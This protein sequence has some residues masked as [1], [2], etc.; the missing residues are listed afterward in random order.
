MPKMRQQ[1]LESTPPLQ[2]LPQPEDSPNTGGYSM[3]ATGQ[4]VILPEGFHTRG[5][6]SHEVSHSSDRPVRGKRSRLI[7]QRDI[8]YINKNKAKTFGDSREYH[9]DKDQYDQFFK[10][11]PGYREDV[12]S[13]FREFSTDYVGEPTEVRARLNAIRQ[14]SKEAGL[15]DPFTQGVSPD[16]YYKKLKNYQFEK[17]DKSGFDP[18]QQLQNAFSDEEIIWLLNNMS[19][20]EDNKQELNVAQE[21]GS[22]DPK[23]NFYT[24]EGS[25]GV[26][27]KVNGR[28]EVD[29]NRSG[30]F[31][32]L[33]KGDV[34][35]RAAVLDKKAKPLYDVTYDDIYKFERTN[36]IC[37]YVYSIYQNA[38]M[39]EK[40]GSAEYI[41]N[42]LIY[43]LRIEDENSSKSHY[44]Y[45]C[46]SIS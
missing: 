18:M 22:P 12:D 37:A 26:Y 23:T 9:N 38:A 10:E 35:K 17:G 39:L 24:V 42:D 27:R 32:A 44:R 41:Q 4:I 40:E 19:K 7:P 16:L 29:W 6:H 15:Y 5:T 14:L 28:W 31:Q 33:S 30:K 8:D 34:K 36:K 43:L 45:K 3:N 20:T 13:N 2:I 11:Y 1:Q 25:G 46:Y 21:G